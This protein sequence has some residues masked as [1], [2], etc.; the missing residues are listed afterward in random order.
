MRD[1]ILKAA[2]GEPTDTTPIWIMRQ[3]GRYLPEYR[4]LRKKHSME[5][6]CRTPALT[7]EVTLQPLRRFDLD[8]AILFSDLLVPLWGMGVSFDLVEGK[9]PVLRKPLTPGELAALPSLDLDALDFT[10]EAIRRLRRELDRPLIGFTGGPFTFAS[11]L[12]ER[13]PSRDY[14]KT[15]AFLHAQHREW[16]A[17]MKRLADNLALYLKAQIEA[18]VQMVQIFDS[19]VGVLSP[20]DF[21]QR[22]KPYLT[23]QLEQVGN[24]VPRI[25]FSTGSS[26]LFPEFATLPAEVMGVDWRVSLTQAKGIFDNAYALQGNLDPILLLGEEEDLL[27]KASEIVTEGRDVAGHIFNLGHGI[28]PPTP[29]ERVQRLVDFVHAKGARR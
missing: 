19:W 21:R 24:G 29:P 1:R 5:E 14:P 2:R 11:Y 13:K 27:G 4:E 17:L 10:F 28:L 6:I 8:A 20:E 12:I 18:G 7:V 26:H 22:V 9:G 15:R 16:E 23:A 25:Y 3:A